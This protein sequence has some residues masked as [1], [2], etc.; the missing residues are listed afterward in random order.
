MKRNLIRFLKKSLFVFRPTSGN[1]WADKVKGIS[2]KVELPVTPGDVFMDNEQ[3]IHPGCTS[4]SHPDQIQIEPP[5]VTINQ[6]DG[7]IH[8]KAFKI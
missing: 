2:P 3:V 5:I 6:D 4:T 7:K 8:I 1:S